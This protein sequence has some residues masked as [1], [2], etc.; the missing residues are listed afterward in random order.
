MLDIEA[1]AEAAG[2]DDERKAAGER[3]VGPHRCAACGYG[4]AVYRV[5]PACPMC[6]GDL[7]VPHPSGGARLDAEF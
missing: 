6:A 7:W 3:A 4:V 2:V 1:D 5:L